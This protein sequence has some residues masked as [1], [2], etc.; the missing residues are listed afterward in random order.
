MGRTLIFTINPG[1]TSTKCALYEV[2]EAGLCGRHEQAVEHPDALLAQF[3]SIAAQLDYRYELVNRF[4][5]AR[6]EDTDTLIGCAGRGGMLTPVPSGA[7]RVNQQLVDFSLNSPVYQHAS[8]L[9]APLAYRVAQQ[10]GVDAYI[11]DPVSVDEFLPVAR[12]SGHPEFERFSFVHALNTRA[13]AR[14][15]AGQLAKPF[16]QLNCVVAHLGAGFSIAAI[17]QGRIVDND[18][19]MEGAAFT[20]ERAGAVPPI[21]LIDACF[22]GRYSCAE[23]KKKLYGEGGLYGYLGTRDLRE[24]EQR[25]RQ[26]DRQAKLVFDAMIY[27][28]KKSMAAMASVLDFELDG[29]ILT[30]GLA[31]SDALVTALQQGLS[32]I[33]SVH[34]YPGSN[35]NQALAETT[36]RVLDNQAPCLSWPIVGAQVELEE[37]C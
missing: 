5:A 4:L 17:K 25:I 21:P 32:R 29:F 27:Q 10:H 15:L 8:N 3:S 9:G 35:E 18:N 1:A 11:V 22:S 20:P 34:A 14:K 33:A 2:T 26:N 24:V 30:G 7:I 16:E 28:I 19:R 6:M 31:Y 12:L 36:L 13:T 23:L 37:A